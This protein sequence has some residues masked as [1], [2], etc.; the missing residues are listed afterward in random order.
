MIDSTI[1]PMNYSDL[2]NYYYITGQLELADA[3]ALVAD[4][5]SGH[6]DL[7]K[8]LKKLQVKNKQLNVLFNNLKE[9][10]DDEITWSHLMDNYVKT[11]CFI[12][13]TF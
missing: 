11:D 13:T 12:K 3:Y 2:S 7:E 6:L 4:L 1:R 10:I 8:K 9:L 5:H